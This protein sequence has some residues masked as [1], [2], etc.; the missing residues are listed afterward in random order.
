[1][2]TVSITLY[3]FSDLSG[4]AKDKA[5]TL[6]QE[7][8]NSVFWDWVREPLHDEI[9]R[10]HGRDLDMQSVRYDLDKRQVW[11]QLEMNGY[12]DCDLVRKWICETFDEK[13]A[14]WYIARLDHHQMSLNLSYGKNPA[15]PLTFLNC[16]FSWQYKIAAAKME[17]YYDAAEFIE[18]HLS[19]PFY[20]YINGIRLTILQYLERERDYFY[21][22]ESLSETADACDDWFLADGTFFPLNE[23]VQEPTNEQK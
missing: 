13:T 7:Y 11:F 19:S 8:V 9:L 12:D 14:Q 21:S 5:R 1:M 20:D 17:R 23:Y 2:K 3:R 22:D 4:T 6:V 10:I 16:A 15:I 18:Y